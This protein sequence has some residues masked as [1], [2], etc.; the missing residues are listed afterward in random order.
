M[1]LNLCALNKIR[2]INPVR[3]SKTDNCECISDME[4]F[5]LNARNTL[6]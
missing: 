2:E 6:N 5:S 4:W 3:F 1:Y